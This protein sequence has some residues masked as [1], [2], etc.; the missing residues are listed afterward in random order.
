MQLDATPSR[1]AT[2]NGAQPCIGIVKF[3]NLARGNHIGFFHR[4]K[5]DAGLAHRQRFPY[6]GRI[7]SQLWNSQNLGATT[8]IFNEIEGQAIFTSRINR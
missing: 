8:N 1:Q 4:A 2:I 7:D 6:R 3:C 5:I